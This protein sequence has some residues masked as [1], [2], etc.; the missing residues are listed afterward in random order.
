[1]S[2]VLRVHALRPLISKDCNY[3]NI[4]Y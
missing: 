1:L 4:E 3:T 2:K